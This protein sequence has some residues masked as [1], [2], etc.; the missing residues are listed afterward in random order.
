[1]E[2]REIYK[3]LIIAGRQ[4]QASPRAVLPL[5]HFEVLQAPD[6]AAGIELASREDP[7]MILLELSEDTIGLCRTLKADERLKD[8]PVVFLSSR[9]PDPRSGADAPSRSEALGAGA[10]AFLGLPPDE[11]ELAALIRTTA[12]AKAAS[13]SCQRENSHREGSNRVDAPADQNAAAY[14]MIFE[15]MQDA[16]FQ[17]DLSGCIIAA[18]PSASAMY[19]YSMEEL[20]GLPAASLYADPG[21]RKI[22][23]NSLEETGRVRDW[24]SRSVRKDGSIFWVSLNAR[25]LRDET[26]RITGIEGVVRDITGRRQAEEKTLR[27]SS[28]FQSLIAFIFEQAEVDEYGKLI[29]TIIA[30]LDQLLRPSVILYNEFDRKAMVLK[31]KNVKASRGVLDLVMKIAGQKILST[32]TPVS[33][34]VYAEMV[35]GRVTV[36]HSLH[37]VSCGSIPVFVSNQLGKALN[38]GCYLGLSYLVDGEVLGTTLAAVGE[39]PD[40]FTVGVLKHFAQFT[41]NSLMRVLMAQELRE[42]DEVHRRLLEK[43][44]IG[45]VVVDAVSREIELVNDTALTLLGHSC[46][47][48]L[49]GRQCNSHVYICAGSEYS[50]PILDQDQDLDNSESVMVHADGSPVP[51]L[52][53]VVRILLNGEEKLVEC[54]A[55]LSGIIQAE[56]EHKRLQEQLLQAQKMESIGRLAGGVAHDFNNMLSVISGYGDLILGSLPPDDPLVEDVE[57]IMKAS[58]RS[59]GLTRQLLA[60]SRRQA[61]QRRVLDVNNLLH[62][63]EKMLHRLIGEDVELELELSQNIG[64]TLADPGQIEQV[65]M[66][67]VVNARDAMPQGGKLLIETAPAELDE[68]YAAEHAE[69]KAGD[70]VLISVTD[71]G[72]GISKEHLGLIFD[73]FFTTKETGKGTGLGLSTVYGIVKQSGGHVSVYSEPGLGTTF[74][75]YLPRTDEAGEAVPGERPAERPAGGDEHILVVEDEESLRSLMARF[76]SGLGYEVTLASDGNEA[77]ALVEEKNMVPDLVITDMIMPNMNGRELIERLK[78]Q[79][80]RLKALYMSGYTDHAVIHNYMLEPG[81]RFLQKPFKFEA[82]AAAIRSILDSG[83]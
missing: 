25:T 68:A 55:D 16:Y 11:V 35:S 70:Y 17:A 5:Q 14:R 80:P 53:S 48:D 44:P 83:N 3:L 29:E 36:E 62:E 28:T 37:D 33:D 59:A 61:L 7:D 63:L 49:V 15:N 75:I 31:I 20:I 8:I 56:E 22:L 51:V 64:P 12:A 57:Q 73:P 42:R 13:R 24:N 65:I 54:F 74:R 46:S 38:T 76:L 77:L 79:H 47:D 30:Q 81:Q 19:G 60:F 78:E 45:V 26:G 23:L 69:V 52:K 82:A 50:C 32:E 58:T 72:T 67:L 21:E 18:S 66:N 10:A 43:M 4:G 34:Q 9:T 39:K 40:P 41:S 27:V 1:M 71:T 2:K 6:S